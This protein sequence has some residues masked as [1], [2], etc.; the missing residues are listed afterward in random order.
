MLS[1]GDTNAVF[2]AIQLGLGAFSLEELK[3]IAPSLRLFLYAEVPGSCSVN[4]RIR[5]FLATQLPKTCLYFWTGCAVHKIHRVLAHALNESSLV[6]DVL[7]LIH[8]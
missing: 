6:G 3:R 8:I 2:S 4:V 1:G 5:N 7:S